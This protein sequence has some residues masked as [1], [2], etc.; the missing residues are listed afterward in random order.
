MAEQSKPNTFSGGMVTDLDPAY[1]PKESYFTGLNIRVITNGDNSYS[2]ENIKGPKLEWDLNTY[3]DGGAVVVITGTGRYVIHGAVVV[4]DYIITIEGQLKT[5]DKGWKIRK[6][7]IDNSTG[8]INLSGDLNSHLWFGA[9]LFSDDAGRIEMESIVETEAIHRIYATDGLSPFKS[10]NVKEDISALTASDFDVFK[11][12]IMASASMIEFADS[13]GNLLCGSYSYV[14][15]FYTENQTNYTDWSPMSRLVNVP[16]N[17]VVTNDSLTIR[18]GTGSDHSSHSIKVSITGIPLNY[19]NI[20]VAEIHFVAAN[21]SSINIIEKSEITGTT[22]EFT[23]SGFE[24]KTL[25]SGGIA[26][27]LIKNTVWDIC[28]SIAQKDNRLYASNLDFSSLSTTYKTIDDISTTLDAYKVKSY[29]ANWNVS[30]EHVDFSG[31]S[32]AGFNEH[33]HKKCYDLG[34]AENDATDFYKF[35]PKNYG[36][37]GVP[38]YI[39]GAETP[40]YTNSDNDGFRITFQHESYPV[41]ETATNSESYF[42][43]TEKVVTGGVDRHYNVPFKVSEIDAAYLGSVKGPINPKWDNE[44]RS[45]RR[46][47]C[48]RFGIILIDK[49]GVESFVHHIGDIKMPDGNDPNYWQLNTAGTSSESN[50]SSS[51]A[52]FTIPNSSSGGSANRT[53]TAHALIPRIDVRLPS[54]ITDIISGYRIVRAEVSDSDKVMITQGLA[55]DVFKYSSSDTAGSVSGLYGMGWNPNTRLYIQG[56]QNGAVTSFSSGH[57]SQLRNQLTSGNSGMLIDTPDVTIG[58][59]SYYLTNGYKIQPSYLM[60]SRGSNTPYY[61]LG[62]IIYDGLSETDSQWPDG[63]HSSF[64]KYSPIKLGVDI[65]EFTGYTGN[66]ANISNADVSSMSDI[67]TSWDGTQIHRQCY[68]SVLLKTVVNGEIVPSSDTGFSSNFIN[69]GAVDGDGSPTDVSSEHSLSTN[70]EDDLKGNDIVGSSTKLLVSIDGNWTNAGSLKRISTGERIII[71]EDNN[72]DYDFS[73]PSGDDDYPTTGWCKGKWVVDVIRNTDDGSGGTNFEQYGGSNSAALQNT[74]YIDCSSFIAVSDFS[75]QVSTTSITGGDTFCDIYTSLS[76]F[77]EDSSNNVPSFGISVP[78]ESP[79]NLGYR[80]G[81]Y[82][83]S[84]QTAVTTQ[85]DTY[86]YND[87]YHQPLNTKSYVQKPSSFNPNTVSKNKIVASQS[88]ISGEPQDAWSSFLSNDFLEASLSRGEITDLVNYNNNL[89]SV[90][91]SGIGLVSINPRVLISGEGA[92]ADIQIVSGTG[93]V[94]ERMDY[95]STEYGSQNYNSSVVAPGGFYSLDVNRNELIKVDGKS[96]IPLSL[97]NSYKSSISNITKGKTI[98]SS[99]NG[100]IGSL[101]AG[102]FSGYDPEFRECHFTVVSEPIEYGDAEISS[103]T[104]SDLDGKLISTLELKSDTTTA[105]AIFF[106]KYISYRNRLF[107]VGHE[108]STSSNDS[109]YLFNS[110]VHQSFNVGVVVNDNPTI[111]KIFDT[112]EIISDATNAAHTFTSHTLSDSTGSNAVEGS[113]E[114]IREGIHRVSL[115]G[116]NT[117]RARGNWLKHTIAYTQTLVDGSID[118]ATDRKFN[119][120]AVNTRYRKSN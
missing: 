93:T 21:I 114:R 94:M 112:S 33:R 64:F 59:K 48:Y 66:T 101:T 58:S 44:F 47:E 73:N 103:F 84:N 97:S 31:Q 83:G 80:T 99:E 51:W 27:T 18:G 20:E 23:H 54:T 108:T 62:T 43:T 70:G 14:Y 7:I 85:E 67:G 74:R 102:V 111:N 113:N 69:K 81:S 17:A 106:K 22:H 98:L 42:G 46:G 57:Q 52:P 95:L 105:S 78:L 92:A 86:E 10:I 88:K 8:E 115:R 12:N 13:G 38:K 36:T 16:I 87:A 9:G 37:A 82:Y 45:F 91:S 32:T 28:K 34:S 65:N 77:K 96:V 89:Y 75:S 68:D 119:I 90:Q 50:G 30:D 116:A 61:W 53:V 55:S 117:D 15:R 39:L 1:Q 63:I 11:P 35:I 29:K 24:T 41:D 49:N 120:F 26:S 5:T 2:L 107:G 71:G 56:T 25:V 72:V 4:D 118:S 3:T 100:N 19:T 6:Y 104:I 110:D 109:I 60:V 79:Y 40:G 76:T